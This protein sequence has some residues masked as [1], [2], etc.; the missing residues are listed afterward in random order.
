MAYYK[1]V[2]GVAFSID[3]S[4]FWPYAAGAAILVVG[5]PVVMTGAARRARGLDKLAAFGPLLFGIAMAVFGADHF[6]GASFVARIV[7]SWIPWHLFW[8]YFVGTALFAGA[9]SLATTI[10][11]RLAAASFVLM[12]LIFELT[13][14]L[15]N[16]VAVPNATHR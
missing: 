11:W 14:H 15:P 4:V 6:V 2:P 5:V 7:P 12:L 16:L 13:I 3:P 10:Q 1:F 9:L 8:T